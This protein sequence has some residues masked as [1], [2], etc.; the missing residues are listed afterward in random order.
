MTEP[1]AG[2]PESLTAPTPEA[3]FQLAIKLSRLG[4]KATQ[5]DMDV[6]KKLRPKYAMDADALIASS[7][8][9]A[10]HYQTIAAAN[11]YWLNQE[12]ENS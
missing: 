4:V 3:G 5:P 9:V 1:M 8:V 7:H 2:F 11:G 6:L 10:V 12:Q